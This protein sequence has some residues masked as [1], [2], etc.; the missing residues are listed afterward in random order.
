[1]DKFQAMQ[2]FIAVAD[3]EGF[4]A[5]ARRL[6]MSPPAVTRSVSMLEDHLGAR[7]FTRTTRSV[8]LTDVGERFL[9]DSRRILLELEEAENAA[10]GSHV[11]PRG[12]L[13]VTAPVLFGRMFV[14]PLLGKFLKLYPQVDART[15]YV[16][17]VVNL[18]DEGLEVGIRIGDL[19]DSSLI[20]VRCGSVRQ[21]V[22]GAP[23]YFEIHGRPERPEDLTDHTLIQS[24][25][26]TSSHEWSFQEKGL[27]KSLHV[28]PRVQMNTNDAVIEM[29]L[30]GRGLS[31]VISYQISSSVADGQLQTVLE[32]YELPPM[33]IHV[34]HQQGRMVSGKVRAFVDFMVEQLRANPD[35]Q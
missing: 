4:A 21:V 22:F 6:Y 34:V 5:A 28:R 33:P 19:P 15:V 8:R 17:R 30:Q 16:D 13:H 25:A 7:L 3:C 24:L 2:V 20:A 18:V 9:I 14:T 11:E 31:R 32:D 10:V 12:E 27:R 29:A 26:I 35:L 23:E 1:M